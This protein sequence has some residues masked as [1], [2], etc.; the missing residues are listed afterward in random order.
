MKIVGRYAPDIVSE[1]L[2]ELEVMRDA[3]TDNR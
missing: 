3:K 2:L 1:A